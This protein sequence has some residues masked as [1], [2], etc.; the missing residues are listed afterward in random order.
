M[1][2]KNVLKEDR[3]VKGPEKLMIQGEGKKNRKPRKDRN[4]GG[5][6]KHLATKPEQGKRDAKISNTGR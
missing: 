6:G 4:N 1:G 5:T 3:V 2:I